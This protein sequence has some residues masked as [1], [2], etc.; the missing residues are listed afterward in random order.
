MIPRE[1]YLARLGDEEQAL[2]NAPDISN[3]RWYNNCMAIM[4]SVRSY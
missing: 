4:K 1:I 2:H 3:D